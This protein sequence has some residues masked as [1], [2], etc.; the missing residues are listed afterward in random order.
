MRLAL[1]NLKIVCKI[2]ENFEFENSDCVVY[3]SKK[4]F[5]KKIDVYNRDLFYDK[6]NKDLF[7]SNQYA[8]FGENGTTIDYQYFAN[9]N[10]KITFNSKNNLNNY[11]VSENDSALLKEIVTEI[12]D[13]LFNKNSNSL[14]S[15]EN[16]FFDETKTT[17]D[18]YFK[19][20]VENKIVFNSKNKLND[21]VVSE[22]NTILL[23]E[24]AKK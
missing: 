11:T 8:L 18:Y 17:I 4:A 20:P 22:E 7:D 14:V 19:S 16:V 15:N 23:K 2:N 9:L 21:C 3:D 10:R 24:I 6:K 1:N 12:V 13:L 5:L